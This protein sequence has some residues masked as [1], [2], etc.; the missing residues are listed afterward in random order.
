MTDH[1]KYPGYDTPESYAGTAMDKGT[2]GAQHIAD[3]VARAQAH[4]AQITYVE[5]LARKDHPRDYADERLASFTLFADADD[6]P[7]KW[8]AG[9]AVA[10]AVTAAVG[11]VVWASSVL[12][13]PGAGW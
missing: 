1:T 3:E 11:L 8:P 7:C 10:F 5:H 13:A 2:M 6:D 12:T 4:D 9:L